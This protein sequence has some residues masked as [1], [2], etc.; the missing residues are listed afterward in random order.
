[1][2]D[3]P[4][5]PGYPM[6]NGFPMN[7]GQPQQQQ[8]PMMQQQLQ[9]NPNP[10]QT[11]TNLNEQRMWQLQRMQIENQRRAQMGVVDGMGSQ[12]TPQVCVS[13]TP[14]FS[15]LFISNL[16]TVRLSQAPDAVARKT[17][18]YLPFRGHFYLPKHLF[19]RLFL[20]VS[21]LAL[22]Q[23]SLLTTTSTTTLSSLSYMPSYRC[24]TLS[25]SYP[26]RWLGF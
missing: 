15:C 18:P 16:E 3:R 2:A 12:I 22:L 14:G 11:P 24:I 25:D 9:P 1:M 13:H 5:M 7:M 20:C 23:L 4:N 26:D 17:P 19:T 6:P 8:Q 21:C 10:M